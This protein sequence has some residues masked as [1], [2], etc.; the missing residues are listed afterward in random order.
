MDDDEQLLDEQQ[1]EVQES[2]GPVVTVPTWEGPV[3]VLAEAASHWDLR[4]WGPACW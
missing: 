4:I 1:G 3:S 2:G